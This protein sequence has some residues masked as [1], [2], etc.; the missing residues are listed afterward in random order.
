MAR[1]NQAKAQLKK[2]IENKMTEVLALEGGTGVGKSAIVKQVAKEL[3]INLVDLRLAQMADATDLVGMPRTNPDTK[4]TV[5]CATEWWPKKGTK[6][7]LFLDEPNRGAADVRQGV[8][9]LLTDRRIHTHS[10]PE[11]WTIVLAFNPSEGDISYDVAST[12]AAWNSRF[13]RLKVEPDVETWMTWAH[14]NNIHDLVI[15]FIAVNQN[16]LHS[17]KEGGSFPCPRT[18]EMVSNFLNKETLLPEIQADML[19]GMIGSEA[20]AVF[21]KFMDKNF[22][23]PVSGKEILNHFKTGHIEREGKKL[24]IREVVADQQ[25]DETAATMSDVVALVG[26]GGKLT[27][28]NVDNLVE[29]AITIRREMCM[30]FLKKLPSSLLCKMGTRSEPLQKLVV[31]ILKEIKK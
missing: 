5:Y 1:I 28:Q 6:G 14:E 31:E 22:R 11:D 24:T 7:I 27:V 12:D 10:L 13:I 30:A 26:E 4:E 8:F 15:R 3:D 17:V 16:L 9:Q 18:W 20:T 21:I 25:N 2:M 23:K 19:Q 29:F